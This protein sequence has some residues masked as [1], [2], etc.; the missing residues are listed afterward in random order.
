[1]PLELNLKILYP[2]FPVEDKETGKDLMLLDILARIFRQEYE[3]EWLDDFPEFL[4]EVAPMYLERYRIDVTGQV[5]RVGQSE[6]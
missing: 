5:F 1:M 2:R 4:E 3:E 6:E